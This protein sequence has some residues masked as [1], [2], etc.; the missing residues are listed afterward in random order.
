LLDL[1]RLK[2]VNYLS[3]CLYLLPTLV[4]LV[5]EL[6]VLELLVTGQLLLL[7]H[8]GLDAVLMVYAFSPLCFVRQKI[9][10]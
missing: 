1:S 5:L 10:A 7:V 3:M 9:L 6:L 4:R 2:V 8:P